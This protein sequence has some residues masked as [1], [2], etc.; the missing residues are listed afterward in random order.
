MNS[1]SAYA[2]IH[3]AL[4]SAVPAGHTIYLGCWE[5]L[6]V[7]GGT[8][9]STPVRYLERGLATTAL[10]IAGGGQTQDFEYT[11]PVSGWNIANVGVTAWVQG[12]NTDAEVHGAVATKL[13]DTTAITPTS[14][15]R[16]KASFQ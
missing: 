8:Y 4:E 15:G 6:V 3:V 16:V 5:D 7:V 11:F 14:L 13:L 10:T 1:S 2:K 12:P 9:G